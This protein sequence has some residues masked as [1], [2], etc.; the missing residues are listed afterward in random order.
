MSMLNDLILDLRELFA[1]R[2]CPICGG[3]LRRDDI[4]VCTMCQITAPLT[5]LWEEAD[6][7]M[8]QRF[9]GIIPVRRAAA[10]FWH[11]EGSPWR[12]AVHRFKYTNEWLTAYN[13]GRWLGI[14]MRQSGN[15]DDVDVIIPVPL[16]WWR[17]LSRGYNQSEY[18]ARGIAKSL[19]C[20]V[21]THAVRRHHYN[22]TQTSQSAT[23]RW[24]NVEGIFRVTQP[25][26][27]QGRHILLVDDVF[28]TGATIM[29]LGETMLKAV[30]NC[31][32][33][34]ATLAITRQSLRQMQ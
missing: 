28:T 26:R 30:D 3:E 34:V 33:S 22:R 29:S 31:Q 13:L 9:W 18:I 7:A 11:V 23:E 19:G 14:L 17:R 15:F 2:T 32:L 5:N 10:L 20:K 16:H 4:A 6:N 25:K 8:T 21:L 12:K 1:P 27:L 24:N